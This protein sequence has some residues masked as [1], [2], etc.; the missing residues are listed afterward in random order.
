MTMYSLWLLAEVHE[1]RKTLPSAMR[2]RVRRM[3]DE[4]QVEP[5]PARS[6]A[7]TIEDEVNLTWEVRRIRLE[8]WRIIYAIDEEAQLVA[9]LAVR[10]RPPYDYEDLSDLL[11]N[12]A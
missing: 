8:G 9:V 6:I 3:I 12:L 5:R 2:Q 7:M 4:L 11:A 1:A 10:K